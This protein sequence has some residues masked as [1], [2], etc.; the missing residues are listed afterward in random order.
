M[1]YRVAG[2]GLGVVTP[3]GIGIDA[4]WTNVL[5]GTR[6]V[7]TITRFPT[8]GYGSRI[9]AEIEDFDAADFIGA[10]RLR[11][12]DRFS[13]FALAAT[14]L[15]ID[16]AGFRVAGD[17]TD[18]GVYIGSALG[19]LAYADETLKANQ[20]DWTYLG[21]SVSYS[22]QWQLCDAGAANCTSIN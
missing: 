10:K 6:A 19:G 15:A 22:Y 4:F 16:D 20:G 14:Q 21:P 18:L 5:A 2:T 11:W 9:A 3:L 8:T 13:Q 1:T 7:R 12:T 17:G